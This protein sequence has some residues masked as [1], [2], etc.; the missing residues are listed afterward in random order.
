M[1]KYSASCL[2]V[3]SANKLCFFA[4]STKARA[5]CSSV[6]RCAPAPLI[7]A[8]KGNVAW[9]SFTSSSVIISA[10]SAADS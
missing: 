3:N 4:D 9:I 7:V 5:K 8:R 10:V 1:S 6:A 2:S